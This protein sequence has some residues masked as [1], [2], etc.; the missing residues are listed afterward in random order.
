MMSAINGKHLFILNTEQHTAPAA[1]SLPEVTLVCIDTVN[2][3][4]A[5]A[6]MQRCMG[7]LHF[8][9]AL[10]LTNQAVTPS[11]GIDIEQIEGIVDIE[12]YSE[13]VIRRL[14]QHITTAYALL[15]Q[16]DGF[17]IN[18]DAWDPAF[19]D[20]DYIGATWPATADQP[21]MVGNGGFSLR[22]KKLLQA[23]QNIKFS[24]FHPEDELIART[25]RAELESLGIRFAPPEIGDHFAYEFKKP[26]TATFGFHGFSNFPDF[27]SRAELEAF[28]SAMPGGLIFNNYFLEFMR[29]VLAQ[30]TIR[31]NEQSL[32]QMLML[33]TSMNISNA[34]KNHLISDQTKHLIS[35]L[36]RLRLGSLARQLAL[37][38]FK[39][40]PSLNNFRLLTKSFLA[41]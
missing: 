33:T 16:W 30:T 37:G 4:L 36:C 15:V 20:Y 34:Q 10:L 1:I 2:P 24:Q 13:F 39:A 7:G 5:M 3:A 18:P 8:A 11:T 28:I 19:L 25:Y 21:E 29:K 6:A 9:R 35:G 31:P 26:L 27:M 41:R 12:S 17:I 32:R 22:S 38:R 23:L 40:A 14:G